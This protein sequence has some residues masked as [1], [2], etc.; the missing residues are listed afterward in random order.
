MILTYSIANDTLNGICYP[1]SLKNEIEKSTITIALAGITLSDDDILIEFKANLTTQE[2][3]DLADL[4]AA[5]EGKRAV[6]DAQKMQLVDSNQDPVGSIDDN[7]VRR[8]AF[9]FGAMTLV[10]PQGPQGDVGPQGPQGIPGTGSNYGNEYQYAESEGES[11][12]TSGS[13][14]NKVNLT[15]SALAG[16]DYRISWFYEVYTTDNDMNIRVQ[17]DDTTNLTEHEHTSVDEGDKHYW[18]SHSGFMKVTLSA[19]S[20][21]IDIDWNDDGGG[22]AKIRRARLEIKKI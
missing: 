1:V 2:Q 11:S 7:G 22:S 20:H 15:T 4:I 8:L 5:H 9:D 16:G 18:A 10:G 13:F 17:L 12:T 6:E 21:F 14:Q 19:A 3:T